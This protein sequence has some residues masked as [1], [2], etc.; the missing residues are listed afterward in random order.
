MGIFSDGL[1]ATALRLL[2]TYGQA[3]SAEVRTTSYNPNTGDITVINNDGYAG[4]GYPS[5]YAQSDIDGHVIM[6]DDTLLIFSVLNTEVPAVNDIFVIGTKR[7]T[8]LSVQKVT[9]QGSNIIYKIQL[10]Q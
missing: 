2:T 3:I 7:L 6:Q 9:A 5:N 10:R 4:Y 8:A 1:T